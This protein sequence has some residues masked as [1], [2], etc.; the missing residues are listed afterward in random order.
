[1]KKCLKKNLQLIN[2]VEEG[3][4]NVAKVKNL[5]KSGADVNTNDYGLS[6]LTIVI[7][8]EDLEMLKILIDM[9]ADI[10]Q[11]DG[12]GITPMEAAQAIN[13]KKVIRFLKNRKSN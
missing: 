3:V 4:V 9:G 8:K 10:N 2:A 7:E 11:P 13:S 6:P 5:I 1:M 12:E